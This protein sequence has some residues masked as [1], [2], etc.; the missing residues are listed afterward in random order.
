MP[1]TWA[2]PVRLPEPLRAAILAH[3]AASA[4]DE[5]CGLLATD[6]DGGIRFVYPTRNAS[7]SPVTFTIDPEDHYQA[8]THAEAQGWEIRGVFH[9]HPHGPVRPSMI[10]VR[11]APD[12]DWIYLITDLVEVRAFRIARGEVEEIPLGADTARRLA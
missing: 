5:C 2:D 7:P 12:P 8:I 11:N 9:S 6:G 3:A 10:D 4:P 1:G